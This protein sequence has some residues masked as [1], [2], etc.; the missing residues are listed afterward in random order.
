M[1]ANLHRLVVINIF[2]AILFGCQ[3][4]PSGEERS[5]EPP[6]PPQPLVQ[7][8]TYRV[9]QR[10]PHDTK[11][12][13]QG[14][15]VFKGAFLESTGQNGS[16]SL[17]KVSIATGKVV[18][19][20]LLDAKY[21]GEGITQLNGNV[22]MLTWLNQQGLVFDASTLQQ[23]QTFSYSGEGWGITNDGKYLYMSNGTSIINVVDPTTWSVV[24]SMAVTMD[25]MAVSSINELEWINGEIWA[26]VWQS[27]KI[28][29]ISPATGVVTGILD[30]TGLLLTNERTPTTDVLNGIAW[31]AQT[32]TVY[33]TGKN[34]PSV[35]A[36]SV[37]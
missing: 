2:C 32:A 25:G 17:R 18:K 36:L 12:F 34:W 37:Q 10:L 30:L 28:I 26:N 35:F 13:T 16:S 8:L 31:D 20:T 5:T 7:Q 24:R 3:D 6:K 33:V 1:T 29:R 4:K 9:I 23:K 14:L 27:D 21:F 15:E 19:K 11:A 22:Y